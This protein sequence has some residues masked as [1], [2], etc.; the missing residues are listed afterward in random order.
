MVHAAPLKVQLEMGAKVQFLKILE[1]KVGKVKLGKW[2]S[3]VGKAPTWIQERSWVRVS[4]GVVQRPLKSTN[5]ETP[6]SHTTL[7]LLQILS[8]PTLTKGNP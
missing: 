6:Q 4:F 2:A 3:L 7:G 5:P 8:Q 1:A